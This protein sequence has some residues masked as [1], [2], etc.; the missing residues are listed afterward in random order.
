MTRYHNVSNFL[1]RNQCIQS[2]SVYIDDVALDKI[3]KIVFFLPL[4]QVKRLC[5][6]INSIGML[7]RLHI[8]R[9][10]H[11]F[12]ALL[13]VKDQ[14]RFPITNPNLLNDVSMCS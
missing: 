2:L 10:C 5:C 7:A 1:G 3:P 6:N 14:K 9:Q 11:S 8:S 12:Q 13:S 4:G